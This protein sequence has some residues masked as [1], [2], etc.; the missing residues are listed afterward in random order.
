[1]RDATCVDCGERFIYNHRGRPRVACSECRPPRSPPTL[2]VARA[3]ACDD[4]G[5]VLVLFPGHESCRS[6]RLG[7]R[8]DRRTI[9]PDVARAMAAKRWANYSPPPKP[10]K[11]TKFCVECG[12]PLTGRQT[13][14]CSKQCRNA[15]LSK[16]D[17]SKLARNRWRAANPGGV[18]HPSV[19]AVCGREWLAKRRNAKL[20]SDSCRSEWYR[21]HPPLPGGP[22][23]DTFQPFTRPDRWK[24]ARVKLRRARLGLGGFGH[25]LYVGP[26][27][28]V[29]LKRPWSKPSSKSV[30]R[31]VRLE[32][33]E[34]DGWVCQ[35]C[36]GPV[37][38]DAHYLDPWSP[39]LDHIECQSWVLVPDHSP[40]NLRLAHRWCN[41]VRGDERF[42]TEDDLAA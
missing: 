42:Y 19:C 25:R 1:M 4:C 5:V 7:Q 33:Y 34:R 2:P 18:K 11:P 9:D 14:V 6:C 39:T 17:A 12:G 26:D 37:D 23:R 22:D 3:R 20:C 31:A 32:V 29:H 15:R 24:A 40:E 30:P 28:T 27:G 16:S 36:D 10:P 21:R 35:L 13:K 38:R 8:N 41:S